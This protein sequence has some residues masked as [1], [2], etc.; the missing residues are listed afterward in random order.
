MKFRFTILIFFLAFVLQTTFLNTFAIAGVTPSLIVIL[1][2]CYYFFNKEPAGIATALVFAVLLDIAFGGLIGVTPLALVI[3]YFVVISLKDN[4]NVENLVVAIPIG[5]FSTIIF[6]TVYFSVYKFFGSIYTFSYW[7]KMEL[8]KIP[9]S[10]VVFAVVYLVFLKI[11]TGKR[12]RY[13]SW[14]RF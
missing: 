2:I 9:Y 8:V 4:F 1:L 12:D 6:D 10:L 14:G 7:L 5:M 3:V 11:Y 13:R